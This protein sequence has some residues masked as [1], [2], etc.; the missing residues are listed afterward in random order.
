MRARALAELALDAGS[1]KPD[2]LRDAERA[3]RAAYHELVAT[4]AHDGHAPST[5]QD[6]I[7]VVEQVSR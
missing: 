1:R 6:V 5:D 3:I 4:Q 7:D 2:P